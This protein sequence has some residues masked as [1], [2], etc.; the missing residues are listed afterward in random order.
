M[1]LILDSSALRTLLELNPELTTEISQS[2]ANSFADRYLK[3]LAKIPEIKASLDSA[4]A[5]LGDAFLK[6]LE[7]QLGSVARH[8]WSREIRAIQ[9]RPEVKQSL[10]EAAIQGLKDQLAEIA[11]QAVSKFSMKTLKAA[12]ESRV[13]AEIEERVNAAVAKKFEAIARA[14]TTP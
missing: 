5:H 12:V 1:K 6:L 8:S 2:V 3:P 14:A 10:E 11:A 13:N 9:L 7:D 4:K